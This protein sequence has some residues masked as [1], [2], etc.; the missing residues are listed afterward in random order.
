MCLVVFVGA[1]SRTSR[2]TRALTASAIALREDRPFRAIY[3]SN[4]K[5]FGVSM[6]GLTPVAWLMAAMFVFA[7]WIGVLPFA[8]PLYTTR[9]GYK[10]IVEIRDMFTQ[11][12]KSLAGAVDAKD[13]YTA[14]HSLRVQIIAKELGAE[15]QLFRG[16][17]RGAEWGGL[18]HDI[19]KIGVPDA[20]LLKQGDLTR[21]ER[22][23]MN[24]H[25][26]KGE[27]IIRPVAKLAPELPVIRHHHEWYNGS[28]YPDGLI[29]EEIPWLA[30]ILHVADSFEAMTAARPYRMTP[31][32]RRSRHERAA[33]V[34]RHPVRSQGRGR[35]RAA[36]RTPGPIGRARTRP[37]S[38]PTRR[39]PSCPCSAN[40]APEHNRHS[41]PLSVTRGGEAG[42]ILLGIVLGL[43][44]GA[45][46][47]RSL[48]GLLEIR[49]RWVSLIFLALTLR[50]GTQYAIG[51]GVQFAADYR[52]ALYVSAFGLLAFACWL[53]R[54][55]PGMIAIALGVA[56]N[57]LAIFVNA[58]WM[59]VW[60][61]SL[62]AVGMSTAD[63][64]TSFHT[65]LPPTFGL[66]FF[67]RAG[68]IG[69]VIPLPLG[70]AGERG[71]HG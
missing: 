65:P 66:E 49:L 7:G 61:P 51:Q 25:P 10:K 12:V 59:P 55:Q 27:E 68:P 9:V 6:A 17:A 35:L 70:S 13:P 20:V 48:G 45:V 26:V 29:G 21:D 43:L 40:A 67:L 37:A 15:L 46:V 2:R 34:E 60:V 57:G 24:A 69:D 42:V 14:G 32:P 62:E 28:G 16:R 30:R 38:S 18:L 33:Q 1:V 41:C 31:L 8:L 11:T 64:N 63:L 52:L 22:I 19:G 47:G 44:A 54:S 71:Q 23:T 58:G 56:S 36:D 39:S 53:N 3:V 5:Q 4:L 50:I